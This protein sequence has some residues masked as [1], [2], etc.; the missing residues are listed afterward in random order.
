[1]SMVDTFMQIEGELMNRILGSIRPKDVL[2]DVGAY[3]GMVSV[4]VGVSAR[5]S[6]VAVHAFE[7]NPETAERARRNAAL[8]KCENVEVHTLALGRES[9]PAKLLTSGWGHSA[10]SMISPGGSCTGSL[11]IRVEKADDLVGRLG[12]SPSI[13]KI[14]VEGAELD[15]LVGMERL[16][17]HGSVREL[18]IEVHPIQLATAG[19][20]EAEL[21][22]WLESRGFR[23]VWRERLTRQFHHHFRREGS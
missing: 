17:R 9:G 8:N 6:E 21:V 12:A 11:D 23:L 14:D 2:F 5:E 3:I 19:H 1:V 18:F 7:P 13:V 20:D 15:V 16:I 4:L 10:D 22:R